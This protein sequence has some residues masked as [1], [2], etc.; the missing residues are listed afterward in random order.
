MKIIV[1]EGEL[2]KSIKKLKKDFEQNVLPQLKR[3]QFFLS[4]SQ[5][6][7]IKIKKAIRRMR[8]IVAKES[9]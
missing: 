3:H 9:A 2:E 8:R 6:K 7:R 5:R 4:K 1:K